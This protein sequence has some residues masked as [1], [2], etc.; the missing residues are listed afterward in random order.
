M[1]FATAA[2]KASKAYEKGEFRSFQA[3]MKYY[4]KK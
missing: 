3:A 2:K 1:K 4:L